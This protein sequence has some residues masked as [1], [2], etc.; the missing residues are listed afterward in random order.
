M[1]VTRFN[2]ENFRNLKQIA[3]ECNPRFNLFYGLNGAGKSNLLES[4]YFLG[5]GKSFRTH[6]LR[7]VLPY[8]QDSLQLYATISVENQ[9]HV[10][11]GVQRSLNGINQLR[12]AGEEVKSH[13]EIARFIPMQIIS[14]ASY[15]LLEAGSGIRRRF[16]D[17][18]VFHVEPNFH[19]HWQKLNRTLQQR[20]AAIRNHSAIDQITLWNPELIQSSLA[21]TK[22]RSEYFA[23]LL[24]IVTNI[25]REFL[26]NTEF[27]ID[28]H[29]GWPKNSDLQ[30]VLAGNLDQ[31]LR[32][33]YTRYGAQRADI[34]IRNTKNGAINFSV[35]KILNTTN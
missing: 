34:I 5:T 31:D 35:C 1:C 27:N 13:S 24:P 26:P 4:I 10:A 6:L 33:G 15:D 18:G 22:C 32:V 3:L 17:W 8:K 9:R 20:N 12:L 25:L 16:L 29:P 23:N 28:F 19:Q 30:Q 14:Q 21:L 7:R 2:V 11:L